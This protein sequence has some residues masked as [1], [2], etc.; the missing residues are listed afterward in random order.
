MPPTQTAPR[1]PLR[2]SK[3]IT[4]TQPTPNG[5]RLMILRR[6]ISFSLNEALIGLDTPSTGGMAVFSQHEA[7][8]AINPVTKTWDDN[9]DQVIEYTIVAVPSFSRRTIRSRG[10]VCWDA[11]DGTDHFILKDSWRADG[12]ACESEFLRVLSG[13]KGVARWSFLNE[14]NGV[15]Q[16]RGFEDGSQMVS[17]RRILFLTGSF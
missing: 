16:S 6:G 15:K 12:R 10:T 17:T 2:D 9:D 13:I 11:T 1:T 5:P 4:N 7:R 14:K 8:P 3:S